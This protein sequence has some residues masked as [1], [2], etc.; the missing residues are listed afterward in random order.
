MFAGRQPW[1]GC[2]HGNS[3]PQNR[4]AMRCSPAS[5]T[6]WALHIAAMPPRNYVP[7]S[8]VAH[9]GLAAW[10]AGNV[11]GATHRSGISLRAQVT[12][13]EE[14]DVKKLSRSERSILVASALATQDVDN[15]PFF[16][17]VRDRIDR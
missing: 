15:E 13:Y 16:R 4:T 2:G 1:S 14:V 7:D 12:I 5:T 10:T 6:R 8:D 3:C 17:R 9:R 11:A